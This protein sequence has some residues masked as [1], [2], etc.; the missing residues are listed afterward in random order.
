MCAGSVRKYRTG[1]STWAYFES[2]WR[3]MKLCRYKK[4]ERL[5]HKHVKRMLS[6]DQETKM[7]PTIVA[8]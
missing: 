3:I 7:M 6:T 8:Y 1:S 4:M 5:A 2:P